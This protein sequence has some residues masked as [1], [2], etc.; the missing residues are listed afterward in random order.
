MQMMEEKQAA[1]GYWQE[2]TDLMSHGE[3][4]LT[5][6]ESMFAEPGLYVLDEPEAAL[7]FTSTLRLVGLLDELARTGAQ[8]VCATHSPILAAL[9]GAAVLEVGDHGVRPTR[10]EDLALVDHWRR[11]LARPDAY[12]RHI[13]G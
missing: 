1:P 11:Y 13:L 10:W 3:G 4:F 5:V 2:R 6:F 12:L 7:S 9:P 8:V